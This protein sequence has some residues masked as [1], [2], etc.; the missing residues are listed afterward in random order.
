MSRDF[1]YRP[2]ATALLIIDMQRYFT[3]PDSVFTRLA[4]ARIPGGVIQHYLERLD[5]LVIPNLR[6]LQQTFRS[7]G[8]P[9][10]Y[11]R[12]GSERPDGSDLPAWARRLNAAGRH[13]F[14]GP[15]FP[16]FDNPSAQLDERIASKP[17]ELVLQKTTLGAVA[18]T[19]LDAE[20]RTRGIRSVAVAG[21]LSAYC[22]TQ[23]ARELADRDFDVAV[24]E[25]ACASLTD[26]AHDA[27][28]GAFA[29]VCGWLLSTDEM[30]AAMGEPCPL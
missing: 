7:H 14:G 6:Q 5:T 3:E 29:A 8:C 30:L 10:F 24:I 23:T 15:V 4:G 17:D 1:P 9:V 16:P 27:A 13:A 25:N 18:S 28:L 22:V 11:T 21:V 19:P 26:A 2:E 20:L 12:L